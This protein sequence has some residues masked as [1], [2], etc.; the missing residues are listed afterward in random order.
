MHSLSNSLKLYLNYKIFGKSQA[1]IHW[2]TYEQTLS[3]L[4]TTLLPSQASIDILFHTTFLSVSEETSEPETSY[5]L[6]WKHHCYS[7]PIHPT[8]KKLCYSLSFLPFFCFFHFRLFAY[9]YY[10]C[11]FAWFDSLKPCQ[12]ILTKSP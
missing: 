4:S 2:K 5:C 9:W 8:P 12:K 11:K 3:N 10:Y 6:R 1:K 7:S